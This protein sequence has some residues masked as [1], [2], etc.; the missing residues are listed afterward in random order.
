M[1]SNALRVRGLLMLA[2][3]AVRKQ[4][5]AHVNINTAEAHIPEEQ[6]VLSCLAHRKHDVPSVRRTNSTLTPG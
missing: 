4:C 1:T 6:V 2:S 3:V 5:V